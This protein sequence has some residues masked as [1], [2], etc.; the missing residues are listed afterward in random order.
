MR[1]R[2]SGGYRVETAGL[3]VVDVEGRVIRLISIRWTDAS[4]LKYCTETV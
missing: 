3:L 1:M 2:G 4:V